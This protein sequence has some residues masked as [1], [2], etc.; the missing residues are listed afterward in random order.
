MVLTNNNIVT[1]A[2]GTLVYP[3]KNWGMY[4]VSWYSGYLAYADNNNYYSPNASNTFTNLQLPY[5]CDTEYN[6]AQYKNIT[7]FDLHS[8]FLNPGYI[9][10]S[11]LHISN[12][13]LFRKGAPGNPY[14]RKFLTDI[15]GNKR[16]SV[17]TIGACELKDTFPHVVCRIGTPGLND[18][19]NVCMNWPTQFADSSFSSKCGSMV[20]ETWNFGDYTPDVISKNPVHTYTLPYAYQISLHVQTSGGC[21]DSAFYIVQVDTACVWPGD[22]D[23]DKKVDIKDVL[24]LALKYGSSGYKRNNATLNWYPQ[25]CDFWNQF[26]Y[27]GVYDNYNNF[28]CN[29]DGVID[30]LDLTA[31]SKNYGDSRNKTALT[32]TGDTIDRRLHFVFDKKTYHPGDIVNA[33]IVLDASHYANSNYMCGLGAVFNFDPEYI[34]SNTFKLT[35]TQSWLDTPGHSMIGF[36]HPEFS[37]GMLAFAVSRTDQ[38]QATGYGKIGEMT[39][40]IP[41]NA[42]PNVVKLLPQ[43]SAITLGAFNQAYIKEDSFVVKA[44]AGID[45]ENSINNVYQFFTNPTNSLINIVSSN[46]RTFHYALTDINGKV[47]INGTMNT[48]GSVDISNLAD[49]IYIL[50][51]QDE[52][53]IFVKEI[54]KR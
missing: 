17:P 50:K 28:D 31:I 9:S 54:Q 22:V 8:Q 39:F 53:G 32:S 15:D 36:V 38:K 6:L 46:L 43:Y 4:G 30:S 12:P 1:N 33:S 2:G 40:T 49:A 14:I 42:K 11:D 51:I 13:L 25:Y 37:N 5:G 3:S 24:N 23:R 48:S 44:G 47:L 16:P 52:R 26:S 27:W 35:Y 19:G 41:I 21:K 45:K 18:S 10:D 20:K 34:D 7:G 29:G